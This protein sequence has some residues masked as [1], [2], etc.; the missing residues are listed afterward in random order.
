MSLDVSALSLKVRSRRGKLVSDETYYEAGLFILV[1][2]SEFS[3]LEKLIF[4]LEASLAIV[5]VSLFIS[6]PV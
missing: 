1:G 3:L 5:F 2:G 6:V 4:C